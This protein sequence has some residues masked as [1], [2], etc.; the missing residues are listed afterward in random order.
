M[1]PH[2][3]SEITTLNLDIVVLRLKVFRVTELNRFDYLE[4][5]SDEALRVS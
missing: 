4:K 3:R 5:P 2:K 1:A